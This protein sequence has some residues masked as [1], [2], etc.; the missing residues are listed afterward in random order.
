MAVYPEK[1]GVPPVYS[2]SPFQGGEP[3]IHTERCNRR[4]ELH[5]RYTQI[6]PARVATICPVNTGE[7]GVPGVS[8]FERYTGIHPSR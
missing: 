7:Q 1:T 5:P 4:S 3:E 8:Q 2:C 6:H